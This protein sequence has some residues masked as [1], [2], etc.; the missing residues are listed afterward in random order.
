MSD[1]Y[2]ELSDAFKDI[3]WNDE[4]ALYMVGKIEVLGEVNAITFQESMKLIKSIPISQEQMRK[5][6]Y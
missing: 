3:K 5:I 4:T 1:L 2:K 6:N